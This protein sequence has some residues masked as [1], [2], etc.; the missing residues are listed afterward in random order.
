[1]ALGLG[2]P[3]RIRLEGCRAQTQIQG[4][5]L[6]YSYV[7]LIFVVGLAVLIPA[8]FLVLSSRLGPHQPT[9]GKLTPY[10]AGILPPVVTERKFQ[11]KF[12]LVAVSFLLFDVE[13]VFLFPWA[14]RFR[15]LRW[16]GFWGMMVFLGVLVLGLIYEWRKGALEWR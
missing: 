2:F 11:V 8:A 3:G 15:E 12:Y 6:G 5:L 4:G 7:P 16:S 13:V 1:M 9:E 14:V 10:E